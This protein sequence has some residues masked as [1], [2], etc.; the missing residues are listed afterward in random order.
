MGSKFLGHAVQ[1]KMGTRIFGI[2]EYVTTDGWVGVRGPRRR[3]DEIPLARV[4]F[5]P[6]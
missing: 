3:L 4:M 2:A 1:D 5:D 6:T